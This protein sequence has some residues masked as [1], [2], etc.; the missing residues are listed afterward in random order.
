MKDKFFNIVAHDLKNPFTSLL[1]SSELLYENINQMTPENIKKL[2]LIL[3]DSAKGGYSIL[4]NL[5]DWSRSQT[6][7][8]KISP[9]KINIRTLIDENIEN[10]ILPASNKEIT[11]KSEL[12]E[13]LFIVT[14]K[15]MVNTVLRNLMSNAIKF[16]FKNGNVIIF[17]N[18]TPEEVTISVKD[19]GKGIS[20]EKTLMLFRI[21]NSLSEPGTEKEQ[22]TGLGLKLCKEFV[23]KLGGRI[24]AESIENKGSTFS[25][26]IP[27]YTH[28][29][30]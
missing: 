28:L 8:L 1:G 20:K 24:W 30:S 5:L 22:G 25:F 18:H 3:N 12:K 16:T 29:N 15:N 2:A 10:L 21:D 7:L 23:E 9:G 27:S 14:D 13:D 4:Q 17:I 26:S 19:T 6:G 11:L